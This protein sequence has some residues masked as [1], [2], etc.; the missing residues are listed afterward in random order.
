MKNDFN[1]QQ[2]LECGQSFRYK[3]LDEGHYEIIARDKRLRI[4]QT[5][6]NINFDCSHEEYE[7]IW[8]GYFDFGRNYTT[9]KGML[10]QKDAI[11]KEAV[12]HKP[13]LR[14]LRQAPFEMI[15]TFILSQNKSMPQIMILVERLSSVYGEV[16]SDQYG[17]YCVFPTPEALR[18]VTEEDYRELKTGFRAPYLVDAVRLVLNGTIDFVVVDQADKEVAREVL[19]QVKGIGPKVADCILLFG[20]AK[21]DV[22]PVDVWIRRMMTNAYFKGEKVSDKKILTFAEGY[23]GGVA[24]IAQQYL[25]FH[26]RDKAL[27]Y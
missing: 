8:Q 12:E 10:I 25:F 26:G 16:V 23:F 4:K 18:Y 3:K 2:I 22:F 7:L 13:G 6:S 5:G 19:M 9:L 27:S 14:I 1:I 17:E 15:I 21:V 24:G 20:F 11:L